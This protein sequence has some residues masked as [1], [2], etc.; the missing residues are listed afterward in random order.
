MENDL[1]VLD[2]LTEI[3]N[4]G[5]GRAADL[6]NTM[7]NSHVSL[8]IPL[9]L[10]LSIEELTMESFFP[11]NTSF[12]AIE[13]KYSGAYKGFVELVFDIE[14]AGKLVD[15]FVGTDTAPAEDFD[16]LRSGTLCEIGNIVIN[17]VLGTMANILD[18]PLTF[19]V[20]FYHEGSGEELFKAMTMNTTSTVLLTKATFT[21]EQL[22]ITGDL[23]LFFSF[24]SY[25]S[26][27][28]GLLALGQ[29]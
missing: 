2:G 12:S 24:S 11:V 8:T 28:S 13:M 21:I 26:L 3:M 16:S 17:S 18:V 20:P 14:S 29:G 27:R 7:L 5:V 10:L 22:E 19:S 15:C 23:A 4:I 6:M 1:R 25:E 9:V